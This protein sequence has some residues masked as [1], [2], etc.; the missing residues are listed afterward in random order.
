MPEVRRQC[1]PVPGYSGDISAPKLPDDVLAVLALNAAWFH[2]SF[3]TRQLQAILLLR[4]GRFLLIRT[5]EM[6]STVDSHANAHVHRCFVADS[7]SNIVMFAQDPRSREVLRTKVPVSKASSHLAQ[8]VAVDEIVTQAST[9]KL[10]RINNSYDLEL[11]ENPEFEHIFGS[12]LSADGGEGSL[13]SSAELVQE[14]A[15]MNL[16]PGDLCRVE[17]RGD[18]FIWQSCQCDGWGMPDGPVPPEVEIARLEEASCQDRRFLSFSK[19]C[20]LGL[21]REVCYSAVVTWVGET[22]VD[23]CYTNPSEWADGASGFTN[24]LGSS[25]KPTAL[26]ESDVD[27]NRVMVLPESKWYWAF[28]HT[29]ENSSETSVVSADFGD[30]LF[31]EQSLR[32]NEESQKRQSQQQQF[33]N[34]ADALADSENAHIFRCKT[35]SEEK[36]LLAPYFQEAVEQLAADVDCG[37]SQPG[38]VWPRQA[39]MAMGKR[40]FLKLLRSPFWSTWLAKGGESPSK[41]TT[42]FGKKKFVRLVLR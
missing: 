20:H 9:V 27:I 31:P 30:F 39:E 17:R 21:R 29:W 22:T 32:L 3:W 1:E 18:T 13:F 28:W 26:I 37:T 6:Q 24:S 25:M 12:F 16:K 11:I 10:P 33:L 15:R 8:E 36:H 7:L 34:L 41:V 35:L 5:S 40:L 2:Y 4:D 42:L 38:R 14:E 23:V 19:G